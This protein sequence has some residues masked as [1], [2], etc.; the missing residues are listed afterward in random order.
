MYIPDLP[1]YLVFYLETTRG[2]SIDLPTMDDNDDDNN[3]NDD[4]L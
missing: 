3:D 1:T 4:T 2:S